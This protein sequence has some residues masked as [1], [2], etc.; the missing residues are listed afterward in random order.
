MTFCLHIQVTDGIKVFQG[1]KERDRIPAVGER[2]WVDAE[3]TERVS[4]EVV[5]DDEYG[6]RTT[7][8]EKTHVYLYTHPTRYDD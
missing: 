2:I 5:V 8:G 1:V 7:E 3:G 4:G 6:H